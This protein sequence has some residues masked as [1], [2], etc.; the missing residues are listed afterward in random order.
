MNPRTT[1]V[2]AVVALL[3]GVFVWWGEMEGEAERAAE[4]AGKRLFTGFTE[5]DVDALALRTLDDID[6]R[7]ERR[8]GR[9]WLVSPVLARADATALDAMASA[10]ANLPT[11][12]RVSGDRRPEQFELGRET[13]RRLIGFEV[14]GERAGLR[15]GRTTPV[16]GHRY[17][18][19]L[20]DDAIAYVASYRVNAFERNLAD[21]RDRNLFAFVPDD[22]E[23]LEL[24]RPSSGFAITLERV[25]VGASTGEG[26]E[27]RISA[28]IEAQADPEVLRDLASNLAHLRVRDFVDDPD[29]IG[30]ELRE[31]TAL[32][33]A[34]RLAGEDTD[35]RARIAGGDDRG[36]LID[37]S[38]GA[39]Y[40]IAEERLAEF[41]LEVDDYRF[42]RLADFDL[43][44]ARRLEFHFVEAASDESA[45]LDVV[46]ELGET[47]WSSAGRALDPDR[48]TRLVRD[49][50]NLGADAIVADEMGD[51]ELASLGLSPP[52]ARLRVEGRA[53][54]EGP[55]EILAD[56][57]FGRLAAG[58][59]LFVQRAGQ[60]TVF[61]IDPDAAEALPYSSDHYRF[62]FEFESEDA[63][64]APPEIDPRGG[65][66]AP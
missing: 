62:A 35:R 65:A 60:S 43:A 63:D 7:F 34:F 30:A 52:R 25:G 54:P 15:V 19:T 44:S 26:R 6:A 59:G 47:G 10:L 57:R 66:D 27:W 61:L 32:D 31:E 14:A 53:G 50:S 46:A 20:A 16:G 51:A 41:P 13:A 55:V 49:L 12:G 21:L 4:D 18:A 48:T 37:P 58:R 40:W 42:K 24:A 56:L 1:G 38:D 33:I 64:D 3:L 5:A 28:P 17:V 45:V 36:R 29:S 22:L 11:E 39:L 8:E 23:R 9:W 2:L